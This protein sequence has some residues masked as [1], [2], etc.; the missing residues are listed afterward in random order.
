MATAIPSFHALSDHELL[1]AIERLAHD[2][3][4]ATVTLI[5]SLIELDVRRLYLGEGYP[6]LFVYCTQ[7]LRL[8]EH[9]A[10]NRIE[11][12]RAGRRHPRLLAALDRGSINLTAARLLSSH[13]TPENCERVLEAARHKNKRQVEE[14]VAS[15]RPLPDVPAVVRKLPSPPIRAAALSSLPANRAVT[16]APTAIPPAAP[17]SARSAGHTVSPAPKPT[18]TP[19]APERYRIQFTATRA[20]HDKLRRAQELL[21]HVVPNGDPAEIFDRALTLLL[22]DLERTRLAAVAKPK[23]SRGVADGSRHIPADVKRAVWARDEGRCAF[24]G[25]RGRCT[26]RGFLEWHHVTPFAA[27]GLATVDNIQVRCASHN[28]YE[29]TLFF[30]DDSPRLAVDRAEV[31]T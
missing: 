7:A 22:K 1:A 30:G 21:R 4:R 16:A 26:E 20:T 9:A 11:V 13:L 10:Y 28:R 12:A 19:L 31:S 14:I 15:L 8:S 3:R 23:S 6:S 5:R 25:S 17:S 18:V 27:G 29:A 24:V 2:E